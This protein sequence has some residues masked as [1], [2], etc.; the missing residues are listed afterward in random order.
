MKKAIILIIGCI[1][2]AACNNSGNK[3]A[4]V[5]KTETTPSEAIDT[6]TVNVYYFHGKQ[7]CKTCVAVGNLA[8]ETVEKTFSGNNNVRFTEINTSEKG[9]ETLI[10]KYEITWNALIIAKGSQSKDL[11]EQAFATAVN[12]PEKL[13]QLIN[14]TINQFGN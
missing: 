10:E 7:R 2:L 8:K 6:T 12:N 4:E 14:E 11:T 5:H 13:T 9:H 3:K 1:V